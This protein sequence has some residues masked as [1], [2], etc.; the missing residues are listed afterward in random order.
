[1]IEK[2][3]NAGI[4]DI[5]KYKEYGIKIVCAPPA[6]NMKGL[7]YTTRLHELIDVE[8]IR[9]LTEEIPVRIIDH[10]FH[11]QLAIKVNC[12][13][14]TGYVA[15]YD[16]LRMNRIRQNQSL[17]NSALIQ[18]GMYRKICGCSQKIHC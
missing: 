1:M 5:K 13:P 6:S 4:I 2:P 18:R 12:R 10:K 14:N 8:K 9:K 3:A 16:I 7:S 15:I 11:N 17:L